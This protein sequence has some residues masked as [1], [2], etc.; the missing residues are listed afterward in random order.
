LK[1][2]GVVEIVSRIFNSAPTASD[3]LLAVAASLPAPIGQ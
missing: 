1:A 2:Y 3:Q